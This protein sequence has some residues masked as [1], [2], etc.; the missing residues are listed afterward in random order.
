MDSRQFL[1]GSLGATLVAP[2]FA[3]LAIAQ[4]P[5]PTPAPGAFA[6]APITRR[7]I[8]DAD[9]RSLHWVRSADE[10]AKAAVEMVCGG[11]CLTVGSHP[12]HVAAARVS[13]DLPAFANRLR[14]HGLRVTQI[15][16]PA[17]REATDPSA[18]AIVAATA[19]AGCTH[20]SL[21]GYTYDLGKPLAPQLDAIKSR[22]ER[23][24]RLNQKHKVTLVCSSDDVCTDIAE[25]KKV[26][27]VDVAAGA[28]VLVKEVME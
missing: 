20:Y 16:G 6:F 2:L 12:A 25:R 15:K 28:T 1:H 14:S 21:G 11:V 7:L 18:E 13:Q 8:L 4:G 23:F 3:D 26:V 24:V 22:L 5:A 10:V 17:I 9:S 19:Q 27:T